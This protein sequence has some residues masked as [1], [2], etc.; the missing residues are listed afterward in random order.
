MFDKGL[1]YKEWQSS[2]WAFLLVFL[3][4]MLGIFGG[5]FS[6]VSRWESTDRYYHS[7]EFIKEQQKN[8]DLRLSE[9]EIDQNLTVVYLIPNLI[10]MNNYDNVS[11]QNFYLAS[12][13]NDLFFSASKI[14]V[15]LLG[16]FLIAFERYTRKN[17]FTA[18][19][20]FKRTAII[21]VK[22]LQ[23]FAVITI[24]YCASFG[25][26][27]L[28]FNSK[29]PSEYLKWNQSQLMIDGL[30]A[31]LSFILIFLLAV[32]VSLCIASPIPSVLIGTGAWLFPNVVINA[33]DKIFF[34]YTTPI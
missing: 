31:Y 34:N 32:V 19:L 33:L 11:I 27:M 26:G 10:Q 6:D 3:F 20:P 14:A 9:K 17:R 2:K 7:A 15:F 23:S 16:F 21:A 4:F 22:L 5:L 8:S 28:Y 1:W 24:S 12:F 30:S 18:L 13:T 29:I 25:F